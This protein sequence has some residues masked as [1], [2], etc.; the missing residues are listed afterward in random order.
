MSTAP[1]ESKRT[2][3]ERMAEERARQQAADRR[4]EQLI[5]AGLIVVV[6]LV[7]AGIGLAV[8]ASK[9][10]TADPE[11]VKPAGAQQDGGLPFGTATKPVLEIYEDFQCPAC[12]QFEENVGP[13]V[14]QLE[15][16]GDAK[17]VYHVLSF[18][19]GNLGNDASA[20]A[21]NA[22]GCAQQQGA[23]LAYHDTVFANQPANEGDG[24]TD[25]QLLEFGK[26]AGVPDQAAF[27]TCVNGG[28]FD[29]WVTLVQANAN[30]AG[31]TGT[32]TI[33]V[34]GQK[35]DLSKANS[36]DEVKTLIS[37]AVAAAKS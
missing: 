25:E 31:I 12:K 23:F 7:V 13:S 22:A 33:V 8:W 28:T 6:F 9:R 30:E 34:A 2:S 35:V 24:Y 15:S 18:L 36:W 10:T 32:P 21:A 19:D 20:R 26:T 27:T 17:V 4:R 29:G 37:N 3:R 16:S 5:R 11:A 14:R 1:Q